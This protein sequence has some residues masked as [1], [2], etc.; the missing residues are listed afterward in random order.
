VT[1]AVGEHVRARL[2]AR[3]FSGGWMPPEADER[4]DEVDDIIR[5]AI[6]VPSTA[7]IPIAG[8]STSI[9]SSHRR[10]ARRSSRRTNDGKAQYSV[11]SQRVRWPT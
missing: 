4:Y 1:L 6:T 9:R 2:P 3:T 8:R 5:L 10:E 11:A 7:A